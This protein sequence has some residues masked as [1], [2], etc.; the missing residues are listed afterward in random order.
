MEWTRSE[1]LGLASPHFPH[2]EGAGLRLQEFGK[3][4]PC[5]CVFRAIFRACYARFRKN[6]TQERTLSRPVLEYNPRG[7]GRLTWARK[8]EEYIADFLLLSRR[9]LNDDEYTIFR[10]YFLLGADATLISKRLGQDRGQV[11]AVIYRI[12]RRLGR[13]F[14][15]TKPYSLYP[16]DEYYCGRTENSAPTTARMRVVET[17]RI[18]R[19]L[20]DQLQVPVRKAA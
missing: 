17:R 5:A 10:Y 2:C 7:G 20:H 14:R 12:M 16:V 9:H 1:T 4:K 11:F 3:V 13:V 18:R 8:D 19:P 6:V 15:E